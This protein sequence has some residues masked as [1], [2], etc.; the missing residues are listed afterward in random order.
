MARTR[1]DRITTTPAS[2]A[3]PS[4]SPRSKSLKIFGTGILLLS[5]ITQWTIVRYSDSLQK[6]W[7][8]AHIEYSHAYTDSLVYLVL[9]LTSAQTTG[10]TQEDILQTA[11]RQN[12]MGFSAR[13]AVTDLTEVQRSQKIKEVL[14]RANDVKDLDS[15]NQYINY[16]NSVEGPIQ[17]TT[18]KQITDMQDFNSRSIWIFVVLYIIGTALQLAGMY[19]E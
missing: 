2:P 10:K 18:A 3:Q 17:A 1:Q 19:Y 12:A 8:Q 15:Y 16:I 5:F 4:K 9:Y 13:L 11:A 14:N 6:R 7:D